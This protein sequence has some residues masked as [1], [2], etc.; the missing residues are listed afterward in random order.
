[1]L[2]LHAWSSSSPTIHQFPTVLIFDRHRSVLLNQGCN[3]T[4]F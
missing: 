2:H 4:E 1:E 3:C